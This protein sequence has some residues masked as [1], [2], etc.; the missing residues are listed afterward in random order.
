MVS[1][2]NLVAGPPGE[3][4]GASGLRWILIAALAVAAMIAVTLIGYLMGISEG[5]EDPAPGPPAQAPAEVARAR[6]TVTFRGA[7]GGEVSIAPGSISCS[8]S[9][10]HTYATGARLRV[11]ATAD[12]GSQ[13]D[14]WSGAC[15]GIDDCSFVI[16]GKRSLDVTFEQEPAAARC[17]DPIVAAE[18][19]ACTDDDAAAPI[20]RSGPGPDC[21][22]G[23]DNDGDG[24]TDFEQDPGCDS[25]GTEADPGDAP[26]VPP[27]GTATTGGTPVPALTT[28]TPAVAECR[29]GKDN[30]DDGL[31]DVEQD[32]GCEAR[33]DSSE[34]G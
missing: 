32:P 14:G 23:R 16:H 31:I 7:G 3:G 20:D 4:D 13:F 12:E 15:D 24:L 22:D 2:S 27:P 30:D 28:T 18:T 34:A 10:A 11:K 9:C 1:I 17:A 19:P 6:L 21:S 8:E 5:K 26:V 25:G 33:S 29:D